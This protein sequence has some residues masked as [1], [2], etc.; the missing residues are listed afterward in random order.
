[1]TRDSHQIP[2]YQKVQ[3]LLKLSV[4]TSSQIFSQ[5]QL[6][7]LIHVR[8]V[9]QVWRLFTL[10]PNQKHTSFPNNFQKIPMK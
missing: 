2:E 7:D 5:V 8:P 1:M 10:K 6:F 4:Q 9:F 3:T